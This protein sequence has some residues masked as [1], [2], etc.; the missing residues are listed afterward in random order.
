M[1]VIFKPEVITEFEAIAQRYPQRRAALLPA[2]WLAQREFGWISEEAMKAAE[3]LATVVGFAHARQMESATRTSW[4]KELNRHRTREL[5]AP[6]WLWTA[7]VGLLVE[8]ERSY[9]EHCR[10]YAL[11]DESS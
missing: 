1:A 5:D 3:Y 9:L 10:R 2:L 6:L 8:H 7:V 11:A 4:Q